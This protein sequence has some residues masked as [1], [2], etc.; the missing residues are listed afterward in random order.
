MNGLSIQQSHIERYRDH[1]TAEERSPVTIEKYIRDI[2]K[3]ALF[4]GD[5]VITK[6]H[7]IAYKQSLI[8][9]GYSV[10]SINSMLVSVNQ[11]LTF[12][13][14]SDCR[15]KCMKLQRKI[16]QSPDK[17]LTRAEYLRLVEAAGSNLRLSLLLQT[18]CSTGIR[19]SEL[20]F[21]TVES[22]QRG[23]VI[24]TCKNKTRTVLVPGSLRKKILH[25]AKQNHIRSGPVFCSR[26]GRPLDRSNIWSMMKKLCEK[27]DVLPSK[28][29]PHNLRKLFARTFYKVEKD[30]AKLADVLGHSSIDT[31]RIYIISTGKEHLHKIERLGFVT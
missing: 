31:T 7:M 5:D 12:W 3:F 23:E 2:R 22:L 26:N 25:Y 8:D 13:G 4:I 9:Q 17:Q 10:S 14:M 28:V 15:V 11:F 24:V 27:A 1:L 29:F 21:F 18:I 16:Y 30:I 19:V 20:Q 6:S